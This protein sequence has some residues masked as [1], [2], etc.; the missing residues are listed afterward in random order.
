MF[1]T[2]VLLNTICVL[3]VIC[4]SDRIIDVPIVCTIKHVAT[5]GYLRQTQQVKGF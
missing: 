4:M 2:E 1:F 3:Y 5:E